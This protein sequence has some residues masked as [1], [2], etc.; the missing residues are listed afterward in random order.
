MK[1]FTFYLYMMVLCFGTRSYDLFSGTEVNFF[2]QGNSLKKL[3]S[4]LKEE[5]IKKTIACERFCM[6]WHFWI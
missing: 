5:C 6:K 4:I 1:Y 2:P 3:R